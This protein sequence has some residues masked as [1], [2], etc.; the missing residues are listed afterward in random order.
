M[1]NKTATFDNKVILVEKGDVFSKNGEK[2][3]HFNNYFNDITKAINIKK[4]CNSNKLS[5]D[6]LLNAI[7]K[8]ENH[9]SIIKIKPHV[10]TAQL[11]DFNFVNRDGI[12]S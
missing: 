6:P 1:Y 11:F 8:F 12:K 10:E 7:R 5:D 9:P 3:N 4:W 2:T